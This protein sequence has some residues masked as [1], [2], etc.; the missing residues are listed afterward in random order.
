MRPSDRP[1]VNRPM[2]TGL[3]FKVLLLDFAHLL[4]LRALQLGSRSL[5]CTRM[6]WDAHQIRVDLI[7]GTGLDTRQIR[8]V[9]SS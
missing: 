4:A 7:S 6:F 8:F 3:P 1:Q 9:A 5:A 2:P